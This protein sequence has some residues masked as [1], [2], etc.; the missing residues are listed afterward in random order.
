MCVLVRVCVSIGGAS[1]VCQTVPDRTV[2][3]SAIFFKQQSGQIKAAVLFS[4]TPIA[5]IKS[6]QQ[7]LGQHGAE[8]LYRLNTHTDTSWVLWAQAT[9]QKS[10]QK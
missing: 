4:N 5:L 2:P 1:G 3:L 9:I 8:S 10:G 6:V 7:L